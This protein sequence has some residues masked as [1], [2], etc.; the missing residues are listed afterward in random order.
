VIGAI[1]AEFVGATGGLGYLIL[2]QMHTLETARV[3]AVLVVLSL[4]GIV[5]SWVIRVAARKALFWHES[6]RGT[7]S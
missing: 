3:F 2:Q 4:L 5:L 6:E 1:V 7:P